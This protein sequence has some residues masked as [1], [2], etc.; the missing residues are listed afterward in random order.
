MKSGTIDA[1]PTIRQRFEGPRRVSDIFL[2]YHFHRSTGPKLLV[3][4]FMDSQQRGVF[5]T[6]APRRPNPIGL[7]VVQL[8]KIEGT[9]LHIEN[10]DI[11][12]GT[13]LLDI[14]PYVPAFDQH[15]AERIGWLTRTNEEVRSKKS[16][17]RFQ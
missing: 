7:S 16:D 13:P 17:G 11:L 12:H 15:P 1:L 9:V 6:R 2:L 14:K 10:V 4:P 3:T 8:V 5:A